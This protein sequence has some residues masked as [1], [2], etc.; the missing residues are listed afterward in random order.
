MFC[1]NDL[2]SQ[3]VSMPDW[4]VKIEGK[5][6]IFTPDIGGVAPKGATVDP[7]LFKHH[8]A[9]RVREIFPG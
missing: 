5:P 4:S 8:E 6:A 7:T 3:E 2:Q 1:Q 9:A